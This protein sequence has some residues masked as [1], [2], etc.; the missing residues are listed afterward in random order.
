MNYSIDER[1][2]C[3][4]IEFSGNLRGGPDATKFN[5]DLHELI[6]EGK[7]EIVADL[8]SVKFMNSSGLGILI[9]GMTTM[10]NAGGDLRIAGANQRIE[11]LLMIT[12]LVTVFKSFRTVEEAVESYQEEGVKEEE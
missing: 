2:N 12:K 3:V 8:S 4:V 10:R 1:Y 11:S 5:E 7:K 9:G 6:D